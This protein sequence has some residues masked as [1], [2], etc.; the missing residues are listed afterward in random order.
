MLVT[1]S[2]NTRPTPATYIKRGLRYYLSDSVHLYK[3]VITQIPLIG[4]INRGR[5]R[6]GCRVRRD[7]YSLTIVQYLKIPE[8]G[9]VIADIKG[10]SFKARNDVTS[11]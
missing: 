10:Y 11:R 2:G 1:T 3:Y 4:M 9:Y 8:K 6:G 7:I 5:F